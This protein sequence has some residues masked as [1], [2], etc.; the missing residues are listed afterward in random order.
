MQF[1]WTCL[2]IQKRVKANWAVAG[3][4]GTVNLSLQ[5]EWNIWK[6]VQCHLSLSTV[7]EIGAAQHFLWNCESCVI[8]YWANRTE[9]LNV[10]WQESFGVFNTLPHQNTRV[11]NMTVEYVHGRRKSLS[12]RF[13]IFLSSA[14]LAKVFQVLFLSLIDVSNFI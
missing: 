6:Q 1:T 13:Y 9:G 2:E 12:Q 10:H 7:I 5:K 3:K 14:S 11:L 4:T 8:R